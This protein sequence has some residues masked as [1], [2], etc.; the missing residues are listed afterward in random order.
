MAKVMTTDRLQL[1]SV[2]PYPYLWHHEFIE[3]VEFPKDRPACIVVK[4]DVGKGRFRYVIAPISDQRPESPLTG[5]EIPLAELERGGLSMHRKAFVHLADVN[6]DDTYNS[7][8]LYHR[9]PVKG[10]F[11]GPFVQRITK[12]LIENIKTKRTVL[13]HRKGK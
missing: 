13:I 12:Q 8:A 11:S 10:R 5:I 9:M 1:G 6:L 2:I 4:L 7:F 3:G